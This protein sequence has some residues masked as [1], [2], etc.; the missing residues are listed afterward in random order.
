MAF[1][2][3]LAFAV[4][5]SANLPALLFT[6]FWKRFNTAGA[7]WSIYGGLIASVVL[8]IFSPVVSGKPTDAGGLEPSMLQRRLRLVPAVQ[9]GPHVDPAGFLFGW[10][11]TVTDKERPTPGPV[12]RGGGRSLT[13][14][15]ARRA[16]RCGDPPDGRPGAGEAR[17]PGSGRYPTAHRRTRRPPRKKE[18]EPRCRPRHWRTSP[19]DPRLPARP[20]VRWAANPQAAALDRAAADR[21]GFWAEHADATG[22]SSSRRPRLVGPAV[23]EVVRRGSSTSPNCV[24]RHVLAGNGDRIA[25]NLEGENGDTRAFS[26]AELTAEVK[27]AANMLASLGVRRGP[28]R[29]LPA[30][31]PGG[32][33]RMLAFARIGA[34][35]SVVFGGF[36]AES[37]R[38]RIEDANAKLV[39]TADG[40]YRKGTVCRSSR[41][42]M[43]R[44]STP[45]VSTCS[46]CSA[47][48]RRSTGRRPRHLVARV[49][50]VRPTEHTAEAFDAEHPLFILYTSGTT[51]KPK[52][53]LHTT[54]GYLTQA[55]STHKNVFDL[56][57]ET[58]VYWCTADVGWVTGHS[59][60][61]YGPLANGATQLMYEGT[62]DTPHRGRFWRSSRSTGDDPVH[63]AHRHPHVH[64]VGRELPGGYDLS[65]CACWAGSVSR[66]TPRPGCGTARSSAAAAARSSTPGG[67]PRP[68]A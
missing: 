34:V 16:S 13:G 28:G 48:A 29:D 31:D 57:P 52:G 53:I 17:P 32:G 58:D 47:A 55:A 62:P 2:V 23:R 3:A 6:L 36:S 37:L 24:D 44:S 11:G 19:R 4:A 68:A 18:G 26:Y 25:I 15:G 21:L 41:Q 10:L 35:H 9:P 40:G 42:S 7:V 49:D 60:I 51:G 67:R 61:V 39:I 65:A 20:A 14:A 54:G 30:D 33:D 50:A 43:R 64:E 59:Y 22:T 66:S 8:I 27:R 46:S 1:L 38:S 5:A 45:Q 63:G 12:R 56:K